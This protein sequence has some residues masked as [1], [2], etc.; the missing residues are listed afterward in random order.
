MDVQREIR[1]KFQLN[2]E[3]ELESFLAEDKYQELVEALRSTRLAWQW[4]GPANQQ[5]VQVTTYSE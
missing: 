3:I 2:S 5:R 1:K 4:M